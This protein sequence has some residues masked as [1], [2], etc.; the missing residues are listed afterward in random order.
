MRPETEKASI[1]FTVHHP[2]T[3]LSFE[4][5]DEKLLKHNKN[6]EGK[7]IETDRKID[8]KSEKYKEPYCKHVI[9]KRT[10][11]SSFSAERYYFLTVFLHGGAVLRRHVF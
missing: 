7:R 5:L 4:F 9:F 3:A 1:V 6:I 11:H 2:K 8:E 10:I